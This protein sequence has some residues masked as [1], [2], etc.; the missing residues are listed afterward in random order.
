M[1]RD[2]LAHV[3]RAAATI[4]NDPEILVVGSQA[5]L[6][7]YSENELPEIAWLSVEADLAFFD[8]ERGTEKA[9]AVDGAIGELSQFHETYKY[10]AQGVDLE[11]AKLPD[12]WEQRLVSFEPTSA[13]PAHA[14]C[15]DKHDLVISKL[16]AMRE[17]DR[18]FAE[19]L[20]RAGLVD[21][22]VLKERAAALSCV[23][24]AVRKRVL[25][26]L[27]GRK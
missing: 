14:K 11:T 10:Y 15:V 25:S 22:E 4:A 17:K 2:Q 8:A 27:K 23:S 21:I 1:T 19:A 5:I 26:W 20:L 7:S 9:D 24:P 16:V 13:A 12:G 3:L 6:G 18:E